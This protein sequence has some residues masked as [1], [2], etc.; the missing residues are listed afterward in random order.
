MNLPNRLT[1]LRIILVPVVVLVYIFP[2]AQAGIEP[3]IF[4]FD[5]VN[6][7]IINFIVLAIYLIAAFTDF[8]DGHIARSRNLQ[9]TFGKFA[10]PIADKML[11][12]TMFLL[13]ISRGIIPVVPVIIMVC[14]DIVVDGCRML[15]ASN[16]K[17]VSA[18]ML[19]KLKTVLQMCTIALI[20]LNNLPFELWGLPVSEL[21][22][23]FSAFVSLASGI[24]YFSQLKD[25][26]LESK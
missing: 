18:Q 7:S 3:R 13:F 11:T 16:G 22:L 10:D 14:R 4:T 17:V 2:Y 5:S 6:I 1:V 19:G 12:T 21:L 23:W 24:S 26:I 8:L 9:T 25:D 20:L 15:A